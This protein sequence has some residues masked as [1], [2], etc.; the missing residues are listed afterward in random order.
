MSKK[1]VS[2]SQPAPPP[3][4]PPKPPPEG[5]PAAKP[6]W[7]WIFAVLLLVTISVGIFLPRSWGLLPAWLIILA[8]LI[9]A[10]GIIGLSRGMGLSGILI[11][12]G[13]NMM[14]LSRLQIVLWTCVILSAFLAVALGRIGDYAYTPSGYEC[15]PPAEAK[16]GE[17]P[18]EPECAEP[19][20]IQL[21]VVLWGLMGISMTTAVASP[22]L[23]ANKT[24]RTAEQDRIQKERE[25][26]SARAIRAA[27]GQ[28]VDPLL[29]PTT[30][31]YAAVLAQ[32]KKANQPSVESAQDSVG[33]MVRKTSWREASFAD[34]FTGEEVS[35]FGYVDMAKVQNLFFTV[36]AVIAYAVM[37]GGFMAA[38]GK[39]VAGFFVFPDLTEGLLVILGISH[40]GYL[41]DKPFTH[42][43]PGEESPTA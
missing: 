12:A 22:L 2:Q 31:T 40:A 41:V 28:A 35:T 20:G 15:P 26:Q 6:G 30:V 33:V 13:S 1:V 19:L 4:D 25:K 27:P 11:D 24:Q 10:F 18:A 21:P 23:K 29:A 38:A 36:I 3:P 7:L 43:T 32:R 17:A 9:V 8:C 34:V 16:E 39:E 14:S 42:S 37:L 5:P